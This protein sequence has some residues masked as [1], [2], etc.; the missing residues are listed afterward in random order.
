MQNISG[1]GLRINM[2]AT[3]TYPVGV[4]LSQFADDTDPFDI[5]SLQI[6]DSAMGLN[7]DLLT[8]SK[9]N[10]I[11]LSLSFTPDGIDDTTL[12]ILLQANRVGRG[13]IGARDV[14]TMTGIY[15]TGRFVTLSNGFIT[16]GM[17]ANS[18]ASAGRLK[19]RTYNFTFESYLT[20]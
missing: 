14:I 1:F 18:V 15:P 16:D 3:N 8:W 20:I 2:I 4:V 6:A 12:S 10:P 7:G 17:P 5:P 13:K 9:A 19:T 11:K